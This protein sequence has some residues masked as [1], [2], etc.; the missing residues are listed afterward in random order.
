[1]AMFFYMG[2][3][4]SILQQWVRLQRCLLKD[5]S[6]AGQVVFSYLFLLPEDLRFLVVHFRTSLTCT[7]Q[8]CIFLWK[9]TISKLCWKKQVFSRPW[10][11]IETE[12]WRFF[13]PFFLFM[14]KLRGI[15]HFKG[16]SRR[17]KIFAN[18]GP[19][20]HYQRYWRYSQGRQYL[21]YTVV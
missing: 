12:T 2:I 10:Q 4:I 21:S 11:Q 19:R 17:V 18:I 20:Q 9:I 1:M 7:I 6:G 3:L 8:T 15:I 16:R 13:L 5:H 14:G